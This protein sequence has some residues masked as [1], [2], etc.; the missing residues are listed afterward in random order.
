MTRAV[1]TNDT[2][3]QALGEVTEVVDSDGG[4]LFLQA[5]PL[6]TPGGGTFS[7]LTPVGLQGWIYVDPQNVT[8]VA[9]DTAPPVMTPSGWVSPGPVYRTFRAVV[10]TWGTL[11]PYITQ[12]TTIAFVSSHAD[13]TDPVLWFPICGNGAAPYI[14]ANPIFNAQAPALLNTGAKS[15][16]VGS[17]N[18]LSTQLPGGGT[19][20]LIQNI[21][22]PSMSWGNPEF[23]G[24]G[25][26]VV[27][28]PFVFNPATPTV[29][30]RIHVNPAEV[31]TWANGDFVSYAAPVNVYL[32]A[33]APIC[34]SFGAGFNAFGQVQRLT[35]LDSVAG[36]DPVYF[37]AVYCSETNLGTR[38]VFPAGGPVDQTT[39]FLNCYSV[40]GANWRSQ[41]IVLV[42][43]RWNFGVFGGTIDLDGDVLLNGNNT[44]IGGSQCQIGF[45]CLNGPGV[46][47]EIQG[48]T[49]QCLSLLYGG[50]T[51]YT[52]GTPASASA[53]INVSGN[54]RLAYPSGVGQAAATFTFPT[55][56]AGTGLQLNGFNTAFSVSPAGVVT[57]GITLT[58][59]HLDATPAGAAAFGGLAQN[60]GGSGAIANSP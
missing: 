46:V 49:A 23:E 47:L 37:G 38:V 11:W 54:G 57:T 19:G 60:W 1:Y 28:Q 32:C 50:T 44:V 43:G 22:H 36:F 4:Q 16:I 18:A 10:A 5:G 55:A 13:T 51:V 33:F 59:A 9:S 30:T 34:L 40:N 45:A 31:N 58:T 3:L 15:R 42:G 35:L 48:G 7:P 29:N 39:Y 8:G 21:N 20:T 27:C 56:V 6:I 41:R 24:D 25:A 14:V 17:N 2:R 26:Q 53:F 52:S 12:D